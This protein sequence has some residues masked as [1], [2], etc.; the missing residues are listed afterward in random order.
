MRSAG[1]HD[2]SNAA[3]IEARAAEWV[4][5]RSDTVNWSETDNARLEE[6]LADSVAQ[7]VAYLR[8]LSL[9]NSADRLAVLRRPMRMGRAGDE[10][11]RAGPMLRMAATVFVIAVAGSAA[12]FFAHTPNTRTYS[13]PV[14]GGETI[15]LADGSRIELNTDTVLRTRMTPEQRWVLLVR[16]EAYFQVH[17]N[18][19]RPFVVETEGH[20]ITDLGTK[21]LVKSQGERVEVALVEGRAQFDFSESRTQDHPTILLPG[22]V[23]VATASA[24]SVTRKPAQILSDELAWRRGILIFNRAALGEVANEVN[25]YS[26]KKLVVADPQ[27]ARLTIGGTFPTRDVRTIAEAA[28]D[29]YGLHFKDHGDEIVISR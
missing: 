19:A 7:E 5:A 29:F 23:A 18:A 17:H 12:L 16:G 11:R 21:F 1:E 13:T 20:R 2:V 3:E 8:L 14:G 26:K 10:R 15:R 4:A 25:R 24:I 22:D 28:Q 9:W 6:W 27:A